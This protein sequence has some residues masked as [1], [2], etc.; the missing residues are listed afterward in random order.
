MVSRKIESEDYTEDQTLVA[1]YVS[2]N[3]DEIL[4][5][6]VQQETDGDKIGA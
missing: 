2:T 6:P 4:K 5:P 3:S 1:V